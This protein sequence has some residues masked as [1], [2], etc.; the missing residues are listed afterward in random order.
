MPA[1][2]GARCSR[3]RIPGWGER[4]RRKP[5]SPSLGLRGRGAND[6][7]AAAAA[8]A[9]ASTAET[10]L[11][12]GRQTQPP[13]ETEMGQE[14]VADASIS[15]PGALGAAESPPPPPLLP[16]LLRPD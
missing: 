13:P 15:L 10:R 3:H 2:P 14:A 5:A 6:A 12:M 1:K 7:A 9:A 4:L 8:A 16:R 11:E